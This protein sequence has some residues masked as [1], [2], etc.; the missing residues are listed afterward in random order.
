MIDIFNLSNL[1]SN[2]LKRG[3]I[4]IFYYLNK[5]LDSFSNRRKVVIP[6]ALEIN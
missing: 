4:T 6:P 1:L 5:L 2:N 3:K